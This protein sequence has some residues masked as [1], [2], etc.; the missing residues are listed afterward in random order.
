MPEL[1]SAE[2]RKLRA[3]AH[4]LQPVVMIGE[5]GLT[6]QVVTE[7]DVALKSHELVKVRVLGDGREAR[8]GLISAVCEATGA[9]PVQTIGKILVIYRPQP[10]EEE[11]K[12]APRR[13]RRK[14]ARKTKRSFQKT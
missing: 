12:I 4:H 8:A 1:T 11:K 10:P 14:P 2:R 7:I 9:Q 13:P 3:Q 5:A 6:P